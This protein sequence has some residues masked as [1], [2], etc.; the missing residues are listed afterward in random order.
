MIMLRTAGESSQQF[1]T[2]AAA[3]LAAGLFQK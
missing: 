1:E 3:S 2:P